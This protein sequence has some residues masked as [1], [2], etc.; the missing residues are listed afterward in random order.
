M[1]EISKLQDPHHPGQVAKGTVLIDF[2][3]PQRKKLL[4]RG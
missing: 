2:I 4:W 3:D 1:I